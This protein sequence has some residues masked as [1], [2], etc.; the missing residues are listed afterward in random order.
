MR[1]PDA[2][3]PLPDVLSDSA[4]TLLS[5]NSD[6]AYEQ[7]VVTGDGNPQTRETLRTLLPDQLLTAPVTHPPLARLVLAG[8]WLWHDWL[9][10]S[11]TIAQQ[12]ET[13]DGSYWHAIL[14]RREG[15]FSNS[16]YWFARCRAHPVAVDIAK[17]LPD[18]IAP[19]RG[20]PMVVQLSAGG[21][22]PAAFVDLVEQL[23][24]R[25]DDPRRSMA[26]AIQRLEWRALFA[27]CAR[28]AVA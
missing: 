22:N 4:R 16:H 15:D 25:P 28:Q 7:L 14:H 1:H 12:I 26:V 5:L 6:A 13:P 19:H 10:E 9:D 2:I 21:W 24:G 3:L 11:H 20:D 27:H 18:L 8:L 23:H 17:R